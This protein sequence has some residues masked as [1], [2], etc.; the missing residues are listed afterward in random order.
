M[1]AAADHPL[2]ESSPWQI[3]GATDWNGGGLHFSRDYGFGLVDALAAVRLS[4]TWT[5]QKTS[6]N[7]AHTADSFAYKAPVTIPDGENAG[8][9]YQLEISENVSIET[10]HSTTTRNSTRRTM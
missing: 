8:I 2:H 10:I 6:A 5:E 1:P 9:T 7:E 4:E 3:N